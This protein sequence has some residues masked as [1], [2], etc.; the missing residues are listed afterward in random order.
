MAGWRG[1]EDGAQHPEG[2]K[3]GGGRSGI[4]DCHLPAANL[5]QPFVK[6]V[7]RSEWE[8]EATTVL[9]YRRL[10]IKVARSQ[11]V[12]NAYRFTQRAPVILC[13]FC[14]H[15]VFLLRGAYTLCPPSSGALVHLRDNCLNSWLVFIL[16]FM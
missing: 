13:A 9:N 7:E 15:S 3:S 12:Q 1:K 2:P 4:L 11:V 16:E 10:C 8:S 5:M 6:T 14:V